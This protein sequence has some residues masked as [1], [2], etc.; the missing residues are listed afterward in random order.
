MAAGRGGATKIAPSPMSRP[1]FRL[2]LR[3]GLPWLVWL[4]LLLPIAQS[5]AA[6]H[7][8]SH[9][10]AAAA[11]GTRDDG[12]AAAHAAQCDLCL[13]AAAA[14]APGLPAATAAL[15]H[16]DAGSQRAPLAQTERAPAR[17][18]AAYHSRGPPP[19]SR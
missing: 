9:A 2:P 12:G 14:G 15:P 11:A 17:R 16:D 6:W 13:T 3:I 8:Y 19:S 18:F 4:A 7:A 1:T 10:G 5:A